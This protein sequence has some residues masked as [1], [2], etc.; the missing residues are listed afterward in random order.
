MHTQLF[1][2]KWQVSESRN[3][4]RVIAFMDALRHEQY[5]YQPKTDFEKK[6]WQIIWPQRVLCAYI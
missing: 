6:L 2:E 4:E 5:L 3:Q 1:L